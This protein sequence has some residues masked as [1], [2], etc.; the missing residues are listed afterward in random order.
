M[1]VSFLYLHIINCYSQE[2]FCNVLS[3]MQCVSIYLD[4]KQSN[5]VVQVNLFVLENVYIKMY[6]YIYVIHMYN[7]IYIYTCKKQFESH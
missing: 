6:A 7:N 3:S 1:K 4:N 5:T 2:L